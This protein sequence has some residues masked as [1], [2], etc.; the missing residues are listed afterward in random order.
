MN[1]GKSITAIL[2]KTNKKLKHVKRIIII[3]ELMSQ[4]F[5]HFSSC[6]ACFL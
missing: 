4:T 5:H 2:E 6:A 1:M 3:V